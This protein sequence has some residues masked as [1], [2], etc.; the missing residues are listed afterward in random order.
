MTQKRRMA[1]RTVPPPTRILR[2]KSNRIQRWR[3]QI[4]HWRVA[5][6]CLGLVVI[7]WII[8]GRAVGFG[9]LNYDDSYYVYQ[10]PS[11]S[12]GFTRTGLG[13]A[14]AQPLVGNWHPLTSISLMLDAEWSGLNPSGYHFTN[15]FLHTI[16]VLLLLFALK[17]MTG[18][19]W[20]SAFVAALFAIHPLRAESVVWISE[21]KDVLSA[22]FF[23]LGLLVYTRYV[24]RSPKIG[25]YLLLISTFAFGLLSKPMLVT[26]PL[27]L[28]VLDYWPLQ[29][30]SSAKISWLIAEKLPLLALSFAA[31]VAA[32]LSQEH[33]LEA[34]KSWSLVERAE[35]AVVAI[36]TYLRQLFWPVD[37]AVF[38]PHS[39]ED[40]ALW[41]VGVCFVLTL[42]VTIAVV[43]SHRRHPYLLTG[44]LWYLG[45]LV[46]V[47][48]L[49]QVGWQAHADR[50]TYLP[51]IGIYIMVAWTMTDLAA[52]WPRQKVILSGAASVAIVSLILMAWLQV[53]YWSSSVT[54]WRHTL[55]ATTDND[56]AERGLGTALIK[57]GQVDEAIAHERAALRLR[58]DDLNGLTNLANALLQKG[59]VAEAIENYRAV[60]RLRPNDNDGHRNLG[61]ALY[62]NR[63]IEAGMAEFREALRIRPTDSDSAYSLGNAY[64]EKGD[65]ETA[66]TYFQKA[67]AADP[68]N[69]AAHYNLAIALQRKGEPEAAIS[70]FR[71]TLRL[72]PGHVDAHNNLAIALLKKG[73]TNEAIAEWQIALRIQPANAEMHNNLAVA[74]LGQGRVADAIAEWRETLRLQPERVASA[75]AVS[76]ILA[77]APEDALRNGNSAL[78][79]AEHAFQLSGDRSLMTYRVLAAAL[80]ENAKFQA[81]IDT[82]E[83][84]IERARAVDQSPI[85][86]ALQNDLALYRQGLPLRDETHGRGSSTTA[87]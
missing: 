26:F 14:F 58:P 74:L 9:F 57:L 46:P 68:K 10:N 80:A 70:G 66:V 7:T 31:S 8:F 54:L 40:L 15:I 79:Y 63:E 49:V 19:I 60:V 72:A 5:A 24:N 50:Y 33:A 11:I 39:K 3:G 35:N 51:Q 29:R 69:V 2:P 52:K 61:K 36:W 56:V 23:M 34:G 16:A 84:G 81:A 38:Y 17:G 59:E 27:L 21:R 45:M 75:L 85:A 32:L 1:Q 48:G 41:L 30:F 53:G 4:K 64:L 12:D 65:V 71:E 87:R 76:W 78:Q 25:S 42:L 73:L 13:R 47:I 44:W 20:R 55:A 77:T 18:T 67:I 6:I 83:E 28:L 22:V 82:A 86:E 62:Q 43:V 37:L